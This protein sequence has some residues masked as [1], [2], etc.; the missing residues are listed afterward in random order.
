MKHHINSISNYKNNT[1]Y[2]NELFTLDTLKLEYKAMAE[3]VAK[4]G[5]FYIGRYETS[6]SS[7]TEAEFHLCRM[8]KKAENCDEK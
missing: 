8:S 5:G 6:L 2:N 3:S 4:N 7:A 1:L